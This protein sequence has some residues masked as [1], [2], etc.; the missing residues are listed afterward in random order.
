MGL[1]HN[2][3]RSFRKYLGV[4]FLHWSPGN[5]I[6]FR[7]IESNGGDDICENL[8]KTRFKTLSSFYFKQLQ[9]L[10]IKIET[11]QKT[12]QCYPAVLLYS[13]VMDITKVKSFSEYLDFF[14]GE[15]PIPSEHVHFSKRTNPK[16]FLWTR[17]MHFWQP[18][19]TV[20]RQGLKYFR[21]QSPKTFISWQC[22][23]KKNIF[24]SPKCSSEH[25]E[26]SFNKH[27][28]KFLLKI[29]KHL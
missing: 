29:R 5:W 23:P 17:R 20:F 11:V 9:K 22:F 19:R 12:Y 27:A 28:P 7:N 8:S 25:V 26:F 18:C 14:S 4:W 10:I 24:L 3:R 2:F 16:L 6:L 21:S 1:F 13:I 15:L